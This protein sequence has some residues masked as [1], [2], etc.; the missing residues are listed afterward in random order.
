MAGVAALV[1]RCA[2]RGEPSAR[3]GWA[4]AAGRGERC[5]RHGRASL[6][7]R[8]RSPPPPS[9]AGRGQL[10]GPLPVSS[11]AGPHPN[12]LQQVRATAVRGVTLGR[13]SAGHGAQHWRRHYCTQRTWRILSCVATPRRALHASADGP[14]GQKIGSFLRQLGC[15][16]LNEDASEAK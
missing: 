4:D 6:T 12:I 1:A 5:G 13:A 10:C 7:R 11:H 2:R 9:P 15:A 14:S 8:T 16:L 3:S